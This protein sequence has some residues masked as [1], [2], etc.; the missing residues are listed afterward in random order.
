[1][2]SNDEVR[3]FLIDGY[4][5]EICPPVSDPA[6]RECPDKNCAVW[7]ILTSL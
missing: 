4:C 5:N 6:D 3:D 7:K 2:V 1:M